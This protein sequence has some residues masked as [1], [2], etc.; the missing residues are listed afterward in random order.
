MQPSLHSVPQKKPVNSTGRL[1][2]FC[3]V[4]LALSTV[5]QAL[6]QYNSVKMKGAVRTPNSYSKKLASFMNSLSPV[7]KEMAKKRLSAQQDAIKE[8][9]TDLKQTD[10][11]A[12][13]KKDLDKRRYN[14]V[15]G[16]DANTYNSINA[17]QR[18]VANYSPNGL[19]ISPVPELDKKMDKTAKIPKPAKSW[20]LAMQFR[21]LYADGQLVKQA[22]EISP[23]AQDNEVSYNYS[24]QYAIQYHNDEKGVRQNFIIK[25][26]P[27]GNTRELSIHI[28][29]QGDW[30]VDKAHDREL[31]FARKNNR[32]GLDNKLTYNDL[33]V[34]DAK[35]KPIPARMVVEKDNIFEIVA[36]ASDAAYP[37]TIDPLAL[38][39][40]TTLN[41]SATFGFSV[42][43]AGDINRDGYS[44]VVVGDEAGTVSIFPG[45]ATGLSASPITVITGGADATFGASVASAGDVNGD[46]YADVVVGDGAGNVYV[47]YGSPSGITATT[48]S[49]ASATITGGIDLTF[50]AS[51]AHAGDVNGD[52]YSDIIVGDGM[53]AAYIF[54]GS[55]AGI[56]SG[57]AATIATTSLTSAGHAHFGASVASAGDV[58]ADGYSDVI[59]GDAGGDAFIFDGA[60]GGIANLAAPTI[61]L[62]GAGFFGVSVSSAGD[63]NG[64]GFSDVIVGEPTAAGSGQAFVYTSNY[65]SITAATVPVTLTV[66]ADAQFGIS[67]ASAGDV[68]GDAFADVI[69]GDN[70]NNAYVYVGSST[71]LSTTIAYT[72]NGGGLG[73]S[74][75][76][77]GDVNG[78]GYSDVIVGS[79]STGAAYAYQGGPTTVATISTIV[80]LL[81][82]NAGDQFGYGV[83]SA[84]DV[85]GDGFSDVLV[86]ANGY[87][88]GIS[89]TNLGAFYLYLGSANGLSTTPATG[90]PFSGPAFN[91]NFGM[92][93]ASAGD[94]NGDGYGDVIIGGYGYLMGGVG[95]T[96]IA[97]VFF[98]SST[99]LQTGSP[100]IINNPAGPSDDAFFGEG[101]AS[102][103]DVNGDGYGDVVISAYDQTVGANSGQGEAY[104]YLGSATGL[105]TAT[106]AALT[107]TGSFTYFGYSVAGA[108]DVNGDGYSDVVI[109]TSPNANAAYVY[110]GSKTGIAN[111]AA[112]SFTISGAGSFTGFGESVAGAGDINGD[113]F[114]DVLI[115]EPTNGAG[116]VALFMG[117]ATGGDLA[118]NI[119]TTL[120]SGINPGDQFGIAVASA[121][122][123]NGDGYSDVLIKSGI[124]PVYVYQGG[125]TGFGA[126]VA[127]T[128]ASAVFTNGVNATADADTP[129]HLNIASAGDVNGDG[130][131]DIIQGVYETN[132]LEGTVYVYYGNA[133]AAHY[134]SN[135]LQ[136]F[137]TDLV[138]PIK[139]DNVAL[140]QFGLGLYVQSPFG[141]VKGRLVW[142]TVGNGTPFSGTPITNSAFTSG[143]Q[144]TNS[145]IAA[146]TAGAPPTIGG[147]EFTSLV[148]KASPAKVT[149]V[150][151]RIQY[152][153]TAV[154]F[155]QEFSPWVY[156]QAFLTT[157]TSTVLPLDLISFTATAVNNTNIVLNWKTAQEQ[158]TKNFIIEHSLDDINFAPL[159]SVN[160]VG[161]SLTTT[162]YQYT[163][164][165]P[166][167]G[168]HYYRLKEVDLDGHSTNSNIANAS[169]YGDEQ[170]TISPNPTSDVLTINYTGIQ[171][172]NLVRI[173]DGAGRVVRQ[174]PVN[175]N[176][177]LMTVSLNGIAKGVY[178]VELVNSGF[179]PKQLVVQ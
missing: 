157:G 101:V 134:A 97:Y 96:G 176:S 68:N 32:G 74:V 98:G 121:G 113:G 41:G 179:A 158:D 19:T 155:G 99:G 93:V 150:R 165:H 94:V 23:S 25:Q 39:P 114:S 90:T 58:N 4:T 50:G 133:A 174:Y 27:E 38:T 126:S 154:T 107:V 144:L 55:A 31:H 47:F 10:W 61:S 85:N 86:G 13:V 20:E 29:V 53:G 147:T 66:A 84:G 81:G 76:C 138:T 80:P 156:S 145:F 43:S 106:P 175:P 56:S 132:S 88:G 103:G 5:P 163:H 159:D 52:G 9:T 168:I 118:T 37:V 11:F 173:M 42:S 54:A 72:L 75:A 178:F 130:Y 17:A 70:N 12:T 79:T 177:S 14:V 67:V 36:D 48:A 28:Q 71:G 35:G 77:A 122:D 57:V 119:P 33:K 83:A 87:V 146:G 45:S 131:S 49:G 162:S 64:D 65:A 164:Y 6:K 161:N 2:F 149:K 69:V 30:V 40:S 82:Q 112:P 51:V 171:Q 125:P 7:K 140:G 111:G 63:V 153:F 120:F 141:H 172:S 104:I 15:K 3:I 109:G 128:A 1:L 8:E 160:A 137:E 110:L 44:D 60:A 127:T 22:D 73:N 135:V 105:V 148:T 100:Q 117:G 123:V 170:F 102:A 21:G 34:W 16:S 89:G 62:T 46:G 129:N 115:G 151:A 152:A 24:N 169:I 95:N 166:S 78:D 167:V 139:Q 59:I 26:K 136:L 143:Q 92:S 142:E 124:G 91:D 116:S 108:G 18:L